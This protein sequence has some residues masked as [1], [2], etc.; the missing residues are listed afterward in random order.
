M[1]YRLPGWPKPVRWKPGDPLPVALFDY[2][3]AGGAL[4]AHNAMFERLIWANVCVP[5]Y[6]FPPLPFYALRCTM[7]TAHVNTYPGSLADLSE[8]L[9]LPTPKDADGV[10]LLKKFSFPRDPTKKDPRV[11]IE[12]EE[13]PAE[14][15]KLQAYCDTDV[16]AEQQAAERMDPM[17]PDELFFWWIDQEINWRG[18][19]IDREGV[20]NCII[21]LEQALER[22]SAEFR[23]ITGF[24]PTQL[25]ATLGWLHGR[26]VHMDSMDEDA[27][28]AALKR[29]PPLPPD[30]RR[31]LE[32][33]QLIGSASVKK[34]YVM[35]RQACRDDRLRNLIVHHG[36]RTG[37][38]TGEGP[39]PLNLPRAGPDLKWCAA[40]GCK[41]PF[42]PDLAQCPWCRADGSA[43][44]KSKWSPA[45]ADH[46]LELAKSH[47]LELVEWMMGDAVK[48]ISGSLR[49]MF[50][51]GPGLE[52]MASDYSAIEAVVTAQ[53]A[54]E[55][56]RLDAFRAGTDIYLASAGKITGKSVEF[57]L[58]YKAETGDHHEDRQKIG[59]VAELGLGFGGWINAWLAFDDSGTFSEEQIKKLILAWRRESPRI[60]EMWGGQWDGPP[61]DENRRRRLY[62][63]EGAA[64]QAVMFPGRYFE[65]HGI[66]FYV[67][68]VPSG[69][70]AL[71]IRL[72]S[73]RELTYHNPRLMPSERDP[74]SQVIIY[75]TQ[76]SNPKY[77]RIEWVAM[78]TFGGRLTENIVQATAH[79]ILRDAIIKLRAA[80]YPT[81][82]HVYDEIVAEIPLGTGSIAEFERI[83][84]DVPPWAAGWP[85][86]ASGGWRGKRYRKG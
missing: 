38:P 28:K 15:E 19:A 80:G 63:F 48:C 16:I 37:R 23:T 72:L 14:F 57:Y 46:F 59:K 75:W 56:W 35:D 44:R 1:S 25:Q 55:T 12:P 84:A 17:T 61:W 4:K 45:A 11:W 82:L 54:G 70:T 5:L 42:R 62:G 10:R 24:E 22:Y 81:V 47:S 41:R 31:V 3:A 20:R 40:D 67:R 18:V 71:K 64:I 66:G 60:V 6:S 7:A 78:P 76:N 9:K 27:I 73:G 32:I 29:S 51:A 85:V 83:M 53:L 43:L 68:D 86:K 74:S 50:Q 77:G 34:L 33:R 13:E 58:G 39:Q 2:L 36:A 8:V 26:S 79:D 65:S 30:A 21:V 52:L 69:G 49:G